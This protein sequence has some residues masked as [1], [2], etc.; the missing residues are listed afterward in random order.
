VTVGWIGSRTTAAYLEPI[1]PVVAALNRDRLV[2]RLVV[3]GGDT[4]I[5]EEWIEHRGWRLEDEPAALASFDVGVMPLPDT[6]WARGKCGYKI[7]QYFS[8]GVPAI[9]S[10]VGVASELIADGRGMAASGAEEW[11]VALGRLIADADERRERG[12]AARAY[13]EREFSYQRWAPQLA[14]LL[15]SLA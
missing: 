13:V 4:G 2:A 3:V 14:E 12:A 5:R 7:L 11:R 1:L 8:A 15:R 9:A 10:P 6:D